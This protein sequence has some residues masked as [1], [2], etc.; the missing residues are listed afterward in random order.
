MTQAL[1]TFGVYGRASDDE[2]TVLDLADKFR[3]ELCA[4]NQQ[5]HNETVEIRDKLFPGLF[6]AMVESERLYA[7]IYAVE[8]EIKAAHSE[9]RDRDL[10]TD[11]QRERL[12]SLRRERT[13]A[14]KNIAAEKKPWL[15][16]LK[17]FR[18][19]K[20]AAMPADENGNGGWKDVKSLAKRRIAYAALKWSDGVR[21]YAEMWLRLDV[22]RRELGERYQAIGLH[23]SIRT[24]IVEASK[25]KLGKDKPGIRY[26]FGR[27]PEP[28]P[29]E[30]ITLQIPGGVTVAAAVAGRNRS[31][32]LTPIYA[33]RPNSGEQIVYAVEHQIG[34]AAEPRLVRYRVKI[35][36]TMPPTA[37][38][39]R[40]SL[41]VRGEKR[42]A[43]PTLTD[44]EFGK[45][46]GDGL[47]TYDLTWTVRKSGVQV[48]RFAGKHVN[49]ALI[50][51]NWLVERRM[52]VK[53]AQQHADLLAN[54]A[55]EMRGMSASKE[56]GELHGVA[57]LAAYCRA[58][59]HETGAAAILERCERD[60]SRARK[61]AA[62]AAACIEKIYETVA[63]RV[64]RLHAEIVVDPINLAGIKRYDSR[65]LLAGSLP[66][67]VRETMHAVAPG[68]L[69]ALLKGYGLASV[70]VAQ[71]AAE[72]LATDV[73]TDVF[74][75]WVASL[76]VATGPKDAGKCRRSQIA[77]GMAVAQ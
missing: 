74:T 21:D 14:V 37:R 4:I 45:P 13:E 15:A 20:K 72:S 76:N 35:H 9:A 71:G 50:L 63:S 56:P 53:A 61:T 12:E 48:C 47:L 28:R 10:V 8:R 55:L 33:N 5:Q 17:Q 62:K 67:P 65:N 70:E 60:L 6:A 54:H 36:R 75:S 39:Q 22:A 73:I 11:E 24:E 31:L 59:H 7:C 1:A 51:P 46:T 49:E 68:K 41:V 57:A 34:T 40:W 3:A 52:A 43:I 30:K 77:S 64:C 29:W 2:L 38:I 25:P 42:F 23:S 27:K 19:E 58:H 69:S 66:T 44:M 32:R 18:E 16:M 26:F